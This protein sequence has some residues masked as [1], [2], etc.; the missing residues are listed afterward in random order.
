[1]TPLQLLFLEIL[2][3]I[4]SDFWGRKIYVELVRQKK[5]QNLR[6]NAIKIQVFKKGALFFSSSKLLTI[7]KK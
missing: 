4:Y 3:L 6:K 2:N 1:M 5:I 7:K